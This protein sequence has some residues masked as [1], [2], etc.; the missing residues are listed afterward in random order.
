M[1]I[2]ILVVAILFLGCDLGAYFSV[3]RTLRLENRWSLIPGCGYI[4]AAE[5]HFGNKLI[6][7]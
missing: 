2:L 6:L 3:P 4:L 5:Y 1:K 7:K